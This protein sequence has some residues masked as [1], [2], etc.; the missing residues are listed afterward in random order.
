MEIC[1]FL[2]YTTKKSMKVITRKSIPMSNKAVL[3]K[4]IKV[5]VVIAINSILIS[6]SS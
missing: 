5:I 4:G 3:R 2:L 6:F 1:Y